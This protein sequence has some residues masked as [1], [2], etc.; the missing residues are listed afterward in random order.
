MIKLRL[1]ISYQKDGGKVNIQQVKD[2]LTQTILPFWLNLRDE[3]YGGM[4]GKVSFE[5]Q[6][7]KQANKGG[8]ATARHLW[9]FSSSYRVL[10]HP[11]YL[12][13][14]K[15]MYSFLSKHCIDKEY[16][17]IYWMLDYKGEVVDCRKHVYTQAFAI[18]GLSEYYRISKNP[19]ALQLALQLYHLI[20]SKG[21]DEK[22]KAY[23]E[24]FDREWNETP[25][26]ML[27]ENGVLADRTMNTHIHV[28]EAYTNLYKVYP[29]Q[30]LKEKLI[31]LLSIHYK[32]IY[33]ANGFLG[34]FFDKKWN[35]LIDVK[36]FGHDI[37][38]SWLIDETLKVLGCEEETY[39]Q[40]VIDVA[41]NILQHAFHSD[42]SL[43]NES[44]NGVID[45]TRIW[46]V[47]AEALVGF[48]NAY[49]KTS[50]PQFKVAAEKVW[51]YIMRYIKDPREKGEWY[52]SV[53]ENG[54]PIKQNVCEPWK[55]SYHNSRSCLEIIE[56]IKE[57]E[58]MEK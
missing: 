27:S 23:K 33:Q 14:A 28:L 51:S 32:N 7:D 58:S 37:E 21:Y 22:N 8:I 2:E 47:Q 17:G 12:E 55:V 50:D 13:M 1:S 30:E 11:E 52:Y 56:R 34:V 24:E 6:V 53:D 20:E 4:F 18:Y 39:H 10:G 38:A 26:E 49:I 19:E 40:M 44:E 57:M 29:N 45:T 31:R 42:G 16:G 43:L 48:Y 41:Y 25:N 46:W 3:K 54:Q 36:S 5:L 9:A 35:H 15:H